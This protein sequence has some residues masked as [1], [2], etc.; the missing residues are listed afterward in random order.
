MKGHGADRRDEVPYAGWW[1]GGGRYV[2][3][4]QQ[5]GMEVARRGTV[6]GRAEGNGESRNSLT[7]I[8]KMT[9][10]LGE[11]SN[12]ITGT[13]QFPWH[14]GLNTEN[15]KDLSIAYQAHLVFKALPSI[16]AGFLLTEEE[17]HF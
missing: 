13:F 9:C 17:W 11:I 2:E 5:R 7:Y 15:R 12:M 8:R 16:I 4:Q 6:D 14:P 1:G 3:P 10:C